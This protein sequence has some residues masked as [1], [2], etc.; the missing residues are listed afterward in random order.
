MPKKPDLVVFTHHG[1]SFE[2][3]ICLVSIELSKVINFH[4]G[5]FPMYVCD[6][7]SDCTMQLVKLFFCGSPEIIRRCLLRTM[8]VE[9]IS[10]VC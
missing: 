3:W 1:Y 2:Q 6:L 8:D 4:D 10:M 7:Q 5:K 9:M